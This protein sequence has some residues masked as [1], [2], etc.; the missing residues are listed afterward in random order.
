GSGATYTVTVNTGSGDGSL[1]LDVIGNNTIKD[2]MDLPFAGSFTTGEVYTVD[3]SNPIVS[4][5]T[6]AGADPTGA[7]SVDFTVTFSE[8]VTGVDNSDFT[9]TTTGA[10]AG[11]SVNTV[12]GS[13]STRTVNVLTGN[14]NGTIKL[15]IID[16]DTIIDVVSK[17][18]GGPGAG[19]GSFTTGQ[20][21]TIDKTAPTVTVEQAAG[22]SDP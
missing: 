15:N 9:L 8:T 11:A 21:Y 18:L 19:N 12:T 17:P 7:A 1:R 20:V 14:G 13:G 2:F 6:R 4:S 10:V 22:Q 16:D 5:I 3:R